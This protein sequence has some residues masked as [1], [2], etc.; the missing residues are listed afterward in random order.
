MLSIGY[1]CE[2]CKCFLPRK[3]DEKAKPK[4]RRKI[5]K[6][7]FPRSAAPAGATL[8]C[9]SSPS[10]TPL[11]LARPLRFDSRPGRRRYGARSP[12]ALA[13]R[14][15]EQDWHKVIGAD[16]IPVVDAGTKDACPLD[17]VGTCVFLGRA[18]RSANLLKSPG[19]A[20]VVHT[21][22]SGSAPGLSHGEQRNGEVYAMYTLLSECSMYSTVVVDRHSSRLPWKPIFRRSRQVVNS[23]RRA[24]VPAARWFQR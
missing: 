13:L 17:F 6:C 4:T 7:C 12:I 1:H 11:V 14:D 20:I 3:R 19:H 22:G 10:S 8:A 21:S 9:A 5:M 23:I 16:H 15:L 18:A 2:N 24:R